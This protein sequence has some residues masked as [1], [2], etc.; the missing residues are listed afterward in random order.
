MDSLNFD[1]I[2]PSDSFENFKN[3]MKFKKSS[4]LEPVTPLQ[5]SDFETKSK[6][7]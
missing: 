7:K 6:K 3:Q 4:G 1:S 2:D 5:A